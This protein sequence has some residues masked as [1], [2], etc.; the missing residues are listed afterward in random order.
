[1]DPKD[2][3]LISGEFFEYEIPKEKKYLLKYFTGNLQLAFLRYY[4]VFGTTKNF[5]D[6]TGYAC[7]KILLFRF[8]KRYKGLTNLYEKSKSSFS[9]EGLKTLSLI[10]SGK[11]NLTKLNKGVCD[12]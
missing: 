4:M 5:N 7:N 3:H 10:E 12:E 1:M 8:L 2:L 9:E 6:H 11:F